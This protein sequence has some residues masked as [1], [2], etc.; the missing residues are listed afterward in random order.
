MQKSPVIL[1]SG[2]SRGIGAAVA[3]MAA[4]LGASVALTARSAE[5]LET[6]A[7]GIRQGGGRA[8]EIPADVSSVSDC[9]W[10]VEQTLETFGR[11]DGLVNNAGVLVPM[12]TIENTDPSAWQYNLQVNLIGPLALAQAALPHLK[13]SAGRIVNVSSG[14]AVSVISGMSAYSAAKAGLN[15]LTRYLATEAPQVTS[16]AVRPGVVDTHMQIYIRENGAGRMQD[17]DYR[18][19]MNFHANDELLPPDV[20]G[21]SIAVLALYAPME[22]SGEF[23]N[24]NDERVNALVTSHSNSSHPA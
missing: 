6:V 21:L 10:I 17:E 23:I 12:A 5:D 15:V 9:R 1:V 19:F 24:W 7:E 3:R 18:R 2:A 4:G 14:A 8:V 22:W 13:E 20:P 11:L 16:L